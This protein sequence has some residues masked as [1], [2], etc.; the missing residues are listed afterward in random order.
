M[1]KRYIALMPFACIYTNESYKPGQDVQDATL[2]PNPK[3]KS[4]VDELQKAGV[5]AEVPLDWTPDQKIPA[6]EKGPA[7]ATP[8]AAAQ[9]SKAVAQA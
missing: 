3:W 6:L 5:I 1:E 7:S 2:L 8:P 4:R 9:P